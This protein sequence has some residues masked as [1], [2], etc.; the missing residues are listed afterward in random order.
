MTNKTTKHKPIPETLNEFIESMLIDLS[1]DYQFYGEF[2]GYI[3]FIENNG[4]S[5]MGVNVGIHGMNWYYNRE[6]TEKM[7]QEEMNFVGLHEILHLIYNHPKRTKEHHNHY[8]ANVA[9]DMIINYIINHDF[10]NK[11]A[12]EPTGWITLLRL[13]DE[14]EKMLK[15]GTA[16]LYFEDVYDYLS[17]KEDE[18]NDEKQ[19]NGSGEPDDKQGEDGEGDGQPNE[20]SEVEGTGKPSNAPD[21]NGKYK[22]GNSSKIEKGLRD[23]FDQDIMNPG[24]QQTVD[25]HMENEID[26]SVARDMVDQITDGLKARGLDK[27]NVETVLNKLHKKRKDH[28]KEIKR[29]VQTLKGNTIKKT[30]SRASLIL[31]EGIKGK[32]RTGKG[33]NV[34]LDTSG[35]MGGAFE[36]TLSFIFQRN[37]LINMVQC[38]TQVQSFEQISS[39]R[40]LSNMYIKGLGGTVLQ[41][42]IQYIKDNPKTLGG[43]NLLILT[44]G[45]TDT[46]NFNGMKGCKKVLIISAGTKCPIASDNNVAVKQIIIDKSF[47]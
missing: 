25:Q 15:G 23:I 38:D 5:T 37:L 7:K 19:Q 9:Q 17:Q 4:M 1:L 44:D 3:N 24:A 39:M 14:Y 33:I 27:G 47:S 41:P 26:D 2:C 30:I 11:W 34:I 35:S 43:F 8:L 18:Y 13:P 36:K 20:Q 29:S 42:G 45:Q 12:V 46:L 21:A 28:L 31:G 6:F 22:N 10:N 16:N 40:E 32:K